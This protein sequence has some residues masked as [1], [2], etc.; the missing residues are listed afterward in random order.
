MIEIQDGILDKGTVN[1][2]SSEDED[3]IKHLIEKL[4]QTQAKLYESKNTCATLKLEINK[5]H[6]V[7]RLCDLSGFLIKSRKGYRS[8]F[9]GVNI[10][11][12]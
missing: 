12:V 9:S 3:R 8:T 4:Q 11:I 7:H 6:K 2:Q 1:N 5:L 10:V